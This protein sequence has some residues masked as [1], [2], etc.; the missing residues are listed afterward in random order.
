[1]QFQP[2]SFCRMAR[3]AGETFSARTI[4]KTTAPEALEA[5]LL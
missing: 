3:V 5:R 2:G 1:M 4:F